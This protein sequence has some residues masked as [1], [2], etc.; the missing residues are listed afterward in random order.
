MSLR[1]KIVAAIAG[2][3][4]SLGLSG[5]LHAR[6]TLSGISEGE[7]ERR[8]L[9]ISRDLESQA[10]E[11]LLTNDI[12]SLYSRVNDL[13]LNSDDLRYVMVFDAGGNVKASTFPEGLPVGLREANSVPVG[14]EYSLTT[15]STSEGD[16]L[17][18]AYPI[19]GGKAGVIRL[20]FTKER[21]EGQVNRLT[22]T[23][24]ALT[25][26]VLLAGLLVAYLLATVLTRPLSR[27][28]E[29]VRGVGRGELS[30]K[31]AISGHDEVG[32]VTA[33][34]NAMTEKLREKEENRRQL[35]A[36]VIAA[37]EQERRHIARELH[38]EAGQIVTSLLLGLAHLEHSSVD[39]A[40]H[41]KATELRSLAEAT[42]DMMKDMALKLRPS[43]LDDVGLV[44]ALQRYVA[45][46]GR[47][48][49][50]EA[51]FHSTGFNGV[52]LEP[53]TETA[54]YRIAQEALTNVI[55]HARAHSVSVLLERRNN[56]AILVV[57]D[58]GL[59]FDTETLRHSGAPAHKLGILGMEERAVLVGGTLTIESQ[60][61]GGTAVFVEVPVESG[62]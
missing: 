36:K 32:Q 56:Q 20:G 34:F 10:G 31:V 3:I 7:L 29:A 59:G 8:A 39:P 44:A 26:G 17:D 14:G 54:L 19:L 46:Y 40:I 57:E 37:Q 50:L 58:D 49:G 13:A 61:G 45:D 60:P 47:R 52:R 5:T 27:L 11:L 28:V 16:V 4:L 42:L 24:L 53:Q 1:F 51:D 30:R 35:L 12:Y 15:I 9:A 62:S 48:Y 22:F 33:A 23:L 6:F 43:T 18:A 25:G 21:L 2:L 41:S 55:K 38:D